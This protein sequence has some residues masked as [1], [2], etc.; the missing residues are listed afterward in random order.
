MPPDSAKSTPRQKA[1]PLSLAIALIV[2]S[3]SREPSAP[4]P[5]QGRQAKPVT[6]AVPAT[7]GDERDAV[8]P[9]VGGPAGYT[10]SAACQECHKDEYASW[11]RSYHRTMTQFPAP[12]TVKADFNNVILTNMDTRFV[13][14]RTNDAFR[15]RV[16]RTAPAEPGEIAPPWLD[17]EMTLVT[18][19]HHMQVF[20][21]PLGQGN[22]QV[23]F[24][25]SWLIPEQR[26]VPRYATFIRPPDAEHRPEIWNFT[27]SRCHATGLEPRIDGVNR[28]A[29]TRVGEL[30]ISCEACHGPGEKHVAARRREPTVT[31]VDAAALRAEI[32][33]P[34]KLD[35]ARASQVCGFCH[36]M[37][38]FDSAE[39]WRVRGFRYRPG[40]DLEQTTPIIRKSRIEA[41]P[42]LQRYLET[43]PDILRDYFWAD[44]MVRVS[45]RDYNG[46]LDSPCAKGGQFTC[47]SCHSLHK[48]EPDGQ[49]ARNR[50]GDAACTQC[51]ERYSDPAQRLAHT[52]HAAD[53][54]G[55]ECYNCHMPRTTYGVLKA[56]RSHQVSSPRVADELA[57]GRP[58]ACNLCHLDK[59]LSWTAKHLARWFMQPSPDLPEKDADVADAVQLALK[60]DAGQRVLVAWHLG[61]SPARQASGDHWIAPLL[62]QLLDDP[63]D[64]VRCVAERSLRTTPGLVPAGFDFTVRPEARPAVWPDI[65]H[66]W[67]AELPGPAKAQI[68]SETLVNANDPGGM[69]RAFAERIRERDPKPLRLRE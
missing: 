33:Q 17:T 55:S 37:K 1:Q 60:G 16:E 12:D 39:N 26:W 64:A 9:H 41:I 66:R 53:S 6:A 14:T 4:V 56:I 34:K 51:H 35:P 67:A 15:V 22:A 45:G 46:L 23:G 27:C 61:W 3:C 47:L 5:A 57:T 44:G 31:T 65:V 40:D 24:P 63:Y 11:H 36:S 18:G 28:T 54:P 2:A 38:W 58:N 7:A 13:L 48:S 49:L 8:Q 30:G 59:S 69:E 68:P 62:A 10:G 32:V 43:H 50:S 42:G 52:H 21:L 20:W 25:F 19:S 29:D